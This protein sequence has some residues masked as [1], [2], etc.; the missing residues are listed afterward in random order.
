MGI[1]RGHLQNSA[2]HRVCPLGSKNYKQ[3]ETL[4][5][6]FG[7]KNASNNPLKNDEH[8]HTHTQHGIKSLNLFNKWPIRKWNDYTF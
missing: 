3:W 4:E 5:K 1:L 6:I 7:W 8:E 2:Y